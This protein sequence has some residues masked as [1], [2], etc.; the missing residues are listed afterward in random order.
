MYLFFIKWSRSEVVSQYKESGM[1]EYGAVLEVSLGSGPEHI[2]LPNVVRDLESPIKSQSNINTM[3]S[4]SLW[5]F[6]CYI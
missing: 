2:S 4:A 5:S 1:V 6:L 3:A